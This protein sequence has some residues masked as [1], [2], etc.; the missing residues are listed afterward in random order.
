MGLAEVSQQDP[1]PGLL[2]CLLGCLPDYR[3]TEVDWGRNAVCPSS[4]VKHRTKVKATQAGALVFC[5]ALVGLQPQCTW[6]LSTAW[7]HTAVEKLTAS[8]SHDIM[9]TSSLAAGVKANSS[10]A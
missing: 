4:L 10:Q 8:A 5:V 3:S 6:W 9:F 2:A 7:T 1:Q